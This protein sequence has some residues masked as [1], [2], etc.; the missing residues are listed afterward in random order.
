[1]VLLLVLSEMW[2]CMATVFN[3]TE[4]TLRL[5]LIQNRYAQGTTVGVDGLI[6]RHRRLARVQNDG[7][8]VILTYF[9]THTLQ[10]I[11]KMISLDDC[12]IPTPSGQPRETHLGP[13]TWNAMRV[14]NWRGEKDF[15]LEK[16]EHDEQVTVIFEEE[17]DASWKADVRFYGIRSALLGMLGSG[18]LH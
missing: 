4:R 17:T 3:P 18:R 7:K 14:K 5:N 8:N 2:S 13:V 1:M 12:D 10:Y 11:I 6:N 16:K 9:D 15:L